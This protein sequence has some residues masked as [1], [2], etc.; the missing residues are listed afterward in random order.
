MFKGEGREERGKGGGGPHAL[1]GLTC[2][3]WTVRL[4]SSSLTHTM[5]GWR[6]L[7]GSSMSTWAEDKHRQFA[8]GSWTEKENSCFQ[9]YLLTHIRRCVSTHREQPFKRAPHYTPSQTSVFHSWTLV[10]PR[11]Q[12]VFGHVFSVMLQKPEVPVS[13][14][15][16]RFVRSSARLEGDKDKD[17]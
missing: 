7:L 17:A 16:S 14:Q 8:S 5:A 11:N 15:A 2:F 6:T 3:N 12:H 9:R 1:R 13:R 4:S 10:S